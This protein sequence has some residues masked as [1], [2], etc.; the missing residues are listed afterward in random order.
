MELQ[1]AHTNVSILVLDACLLIKHLLGC[2]GLLHLR[3]GSTL[4][5]RGTVL[6]IMHLDVAG[7]ILEERLEEQCF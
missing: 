4:G 6:L 3:P 7:D 2:Y 5:R 1:D